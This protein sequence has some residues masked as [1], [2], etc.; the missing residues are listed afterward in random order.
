[1]VPMEMEV[2]GLRA[3]TS[4]RSLEKATLELDSQTGWENL[5]LFFS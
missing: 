3:C 5:F 2:D 4:A 1:M